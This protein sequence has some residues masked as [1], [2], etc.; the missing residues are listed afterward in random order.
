MKEKRESKGW[1]AVQL[2]T[3]LGVSKAALCY[4]ETGDAPVPVRRV[5]PIA[6][7]LWGPD[8]GN[9]FVAVWEREALERLRAR[10]VA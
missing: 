1:T 3:R 4:W 8:G 9:E 10:S 5:V 7:L 6:R 2:A